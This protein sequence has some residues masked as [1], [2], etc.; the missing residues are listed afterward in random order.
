MEI[1]I[2]VQNVSRE[3]VL[4]TDLTAAA[5]D[6]KLADALNGAA[7]DLTD[8]KGRRVFVPGTAIGYVEIGEEQR[9][10]VG[11]GD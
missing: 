5:L 11:F 2:G 9:R 6:K 3:V 4:E 8:V 7:L 1:R 10:R